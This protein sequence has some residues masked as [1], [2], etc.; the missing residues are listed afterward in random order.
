VTRPG[1]PRSVRA[2]T[3]FVCGNATTVRPTRCDE[4]FDREQ[5]VDG[6]GRLRGYTAGSVRV[7]VD[8][9]CPCGAEY[10]VKTEEPA[11]CCIAQAFALRVRDALDP[12]TPEQRLAA[13][14]IEA[15]ARDVRDNAA[16]TVA[17]LEAKARKLRNGGGA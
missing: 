17:R 10:T 2:C 1:Y 14:A 11:T 3:C 13:Q 5:R 16:A 7:S 12:S 15:A 6:Y 8:L 9:V 4:D